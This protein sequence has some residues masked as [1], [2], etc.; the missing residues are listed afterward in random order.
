VEDT[1]EDETM[2]PIFIQNT[3]LVQKKPKTAGVSGTNW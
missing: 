3:Q 2:E 1:V